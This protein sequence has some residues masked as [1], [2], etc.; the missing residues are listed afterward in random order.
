LELIKYILDDEKIIVHHTD[1]LDDV[2]K[3]IA[4]APP[5]LIISDLMLANKNL[6][7]VLKKWVKAKKITCPLILVSALE[8]E[9]MVQISPIYFQKPFDI[10]H[11]KDG[12]YRVL[13]VNEFNAPDFS[14]IYG[15]YDNDFAKVGKVLRLL[16]EEFVTYLKRIE[17]VTVT[18]DQKE[19]KAILHKL[20]AHI[21]TLG[22]TDL[23]DLLPEKVA[24]FKSEDLNVIR[25]I[26]AYCS[27]CIRFEERLNSEARS[28]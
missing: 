11:F 1:T 5:D 8:P 10:Q 19:W 21:N 3:S 23:K 6:T 28:S 4:I 24:D 16:R 12:V 9:I 14:I 26:F 2:L 25:N 22:L 20:I 27:C 17:N 7:S 15:N 18:K 13:G